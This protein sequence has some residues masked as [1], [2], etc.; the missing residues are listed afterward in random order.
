METVNYIISN[1]SYFSAFETDIDERL[2]EQLMNR[3][4]GGSLEIAAISKVMRWELSRSGELVT[5]FDNTTLEA[6]KGQ[7]L[8][9]AAPQGTLQC[10]YHQESWTAFDSQRT[11]PFERRYYGSESLF[12]LVHW[13][14]WNSESVSNYTRD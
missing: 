13:E 11:S 5:P 8:P 10:W 3:S 6:S 7:N 9:C 2:C 1:R 4:W 12:R 14:W